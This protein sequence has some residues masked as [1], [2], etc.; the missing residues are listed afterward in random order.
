MALHGAPPPQRS[1][2]PGSRPPQRAESRPV[3]RPIYLDHHATTPCDPRVVEAMLPYL[4]EEF[5]NPASRTHAFGWSAEAAVEGAREQVARAVG[6]SPREIVFTSGATEANNLALFGAARALRD[7][8]GRVVTCTTEHRA[9]LDP[10]AALEREGFRVSYVG[11]DGDGLI[12]PD[13]FAEALCPGTVLVSVMHAN[14]EIGVIQDVAPLA[15]LAHERGALVHCDAAQSVGKVPV[16]VHALGVDLLS[17]S[18]HKLY[19]PKGIGALYVRR[20]QPRLR[21]QPLQV[22]GGHERGLRSGTLPTPLCVGLGRACE[23][24]GEEMEAEAARVG[25]LRDR[26]WEGL[27]ARLP[28]VRLNG[29]PTRRLPGNLN[30]SF[31]GVEGE[32]LLVG[33]PELAVSTGSACTSATQTPSHVLRALGLGEARAL[34]SLRF[35]LGRRNTADEID[36]AADRV[37]AEVERLRGLSP[38][39]ERRGERLD[40]PPRR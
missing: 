30:V 13:A 17:I 5:G 39:W 16:D 33:L 14:N 2:A 36:L 26:L 11:V 15:A 35:G 20:R 7:R 12:D 28:A 23:I 4:T 34:S 24:A 21:L 27:R 18:G 25:A 19:G 6:A 38:L 1:A 9:V 32:A 10:C 3:Q 8:G 29:H 22:G 31:D 37:V 40:G